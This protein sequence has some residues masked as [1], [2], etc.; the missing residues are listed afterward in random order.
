MIMNLY[1]EAT[2]KRSSSRVG[3][4]LIKFH[5]FDNL[6]WLNPFCLMANLSFRQTCIKPTLWKKVDISIN[7]LKFDLRVLSLI[8]LKI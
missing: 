4:V 6:I 7:S 5:L 1:D 2:F 3:R 8:D